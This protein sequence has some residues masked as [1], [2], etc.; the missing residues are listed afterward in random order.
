MFAGDNP[1]VSDTDIVLS[2]D[3]NLFVMSPEVI[4][5]LISSPDM[6]AWVL[7]WNPENYT[8]KAEWFQTTFQNTFN[9][10]LLAMRAASWREVTGY[11][12]STEGLVRQY[13]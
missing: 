10:N 2:V 6:V 12:G 9:M 13:R 1:A 3:S 5:P 8:S 7:N 11:Q 4:Q